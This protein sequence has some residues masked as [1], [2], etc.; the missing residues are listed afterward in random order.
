[1]GCIKILAILLIASTSFA[2]TKLL[3]LS[4]RQ[5]VHN[6]KLDDLNGV[7]FYL[8][9]SSA[10]AYSAKNKA[11]VII[12]KKLDSEFDVVK[13]N[14]EKYLISV[15]SNHYK[16]FSFIQD[17]EIYFYNIKTSNLELVGKGSYPKFHPTSS[18]ISYTFEDRGLLFIEVVNTRN[19]LDRFTIPL[20]TRDLTLRSE[21]EIFDDSLIYYTDKDKN[22]NISI[23]VYNNRSKKNYLIKQYDKSNITLSLCSNSE[24]LYI[25]ESLQSDKSYL[26]ISSMKR[27]GVDYANKTPLVSKQIGPAFNLG[28]SGDELFFIMTLKSESSNLINQREVVAYN[29]KEKKLFKRSDLNYV[30]SF[31]FHNDKILV[32]YKDKIYVLR[33]K[34]GKFSINEEIKT[35]L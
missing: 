35:N 6:L 20:K 12:D 10:L 33:N 27:G 23:S 31:V 4:T 2:R 30:S 26:D 28:I 13:I 8:K 15:K 34:E 29:M 7:T 32:P 14:E 18:Y 3:E 17:S 16:N 9:G 19:I 1:M 22:F 25:L 21:V 24:N 11:T 5:N